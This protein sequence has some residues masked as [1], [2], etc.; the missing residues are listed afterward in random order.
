[1]KMVSLNMLL[2]AMCLLVGCGS[3][4]ETLTSGEI[5]PE[6][7][8]EMEKEKEEVFAAESAHR[9]QQAAQAK[10]KK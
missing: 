5:T 6:L 10:G 3:G 2:L 4:D 9:E 1:M 7:K 8:A